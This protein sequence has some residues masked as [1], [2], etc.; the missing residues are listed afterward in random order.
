MRLWWHKWYI[1]G[2]CQTLLSVKRGKEKANKLSGTARP[3]WLC[4]PLS[5]LVQSSVTG[6]GEVGEAVVYNLL[7]S[8]TSLGRLFL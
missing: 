3:V 2:N 7:T 4:L 6:K 1:V 5:Q 8:L